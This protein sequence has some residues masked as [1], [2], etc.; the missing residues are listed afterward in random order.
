MA[1]KFSVYLDESRGF[2]V[3]EDHGKEKAQGIGLQ[4]VMDV[5]ACRKLGG[6][7]GEEEGIGTLKYGV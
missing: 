3:S 7:G 5:L 6:W 2:P 1:W 4:R